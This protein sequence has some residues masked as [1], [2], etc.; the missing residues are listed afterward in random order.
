MSLV[1]AIIKWF[2]S[3]FSK[4]NEGGGSVPTQPPVVEQPTQGDNSIEEADVEPEPIASPIIITKPK[5]YM[6]ILLDNGHA[7]KTPGKRSPVL[8]G[9]QFFEYEFNRDIVRRIGEKLASLDIPFHILVPEIV[10]DIPLSTRAARANKICAE[11]GAANCLLISI[12]SD[13]AGDGSAWKNA[14]GWSVFTTKGN[15]NS[16]K[17]ATLFYNEAEKIVPQLGSKMRKETSDGDPDFEENFTII[18]KAACPAILTENLFY[19]NQKDFEI[20][21]SEEGRE[22]IANIH[23]NAIKQLSIN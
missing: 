3:L 9:K 18:Y 23:V 22:A 1:E 2:I 20:L 4:E 16:D 19:D 13:A 14:R 12:H 7:Q 10:E 6:H 17:Y 11:F 21:M 15:T 8:N 5:H